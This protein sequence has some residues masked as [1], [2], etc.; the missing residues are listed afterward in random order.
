MHLSEFKTK[1]I[2]DKNVS[3]LLDETRKRKLRNEFVCVVVMRES[4]H[5]QYLFPNSWQE[6][7]R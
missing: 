3:P 7:S 1:Q 5:P 2:Q 4:C 6:D